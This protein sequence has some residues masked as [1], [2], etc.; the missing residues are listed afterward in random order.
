MQLTTGTRNISAEEFINIF[1]S[2]FHGR[3]IHISY[4]NSFIE[5]ETS[6]EKAEIYLYGKTI[7]FFESDGEVPYR[8]NIKIDD[9]K[10]IELDDC[11]DEDEEVDPV[12][13]YGAEFRIIGKD[14]TI[15][16]I[17]ANK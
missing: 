5:D 3:T 13:D 10:E 6:F 9:I 2:R 4:E 8:F 11:F 12:I 1:E 7:Q 15:V 16:A 17:A 14:G